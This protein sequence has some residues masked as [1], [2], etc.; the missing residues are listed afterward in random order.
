MRIRVNICSFERV[1]NLVD[2]SLTASPVRDA[3]FALSFTP[4]QTEDTRN[5]VDG[6]GTR[7]RN[8]A[9]QNS[10]N[11]SMAATFSPDL[12]SGVTLTIG[13][14]HT[15]SFDKEVNP[16]NVDEAQDSN[17]YVQM[18]YA[19]FTVG[20][21]AEYRQNFFDDG[22]DQLVFGVGVTY[23]SKPWTVGLGWTRGDYEKAVGANGVGPFN[24]V[25]D[26]VAVT[27]AYALGPG[28]LLDGVIEYSI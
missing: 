10:E 6:A 21:A 23:D 22:A 3:N 16:N 19:G 20:A 4:D 28:I 11:L 18:S 27:A 24:A 9:G 5:T 1:G 26:I 14:A 12:A 17:A 13:G 8:D 15:V 7:F 25:H 2:I